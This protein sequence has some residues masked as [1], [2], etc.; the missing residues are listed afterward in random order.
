MRDFYLILNSAIAIALFALGVATLFN[1]RK[2]IVNKLFMAFTASVGVWLVAAC[3]SND[4]RNSATVSLYGNYLVF[5]FSYISSYLLLRFAVLVTAIKRLDKWM[6]ILNVPLI[7]VGI[8]SATPLVVAGVEPQGNVYAINFGPLVW[9]YALLLILQ[10][11]AVIWIFSKGVRISTGRK[12][13]QIKIIWQSLVI[14]IPILMITQ[15]IAPAIT[16][17]FEITD[18][19]ILIMVLPV[20]SLYMSVIRHGLFDIRQAIIRT[21]TY[22]LSLATLSFVYYYLAY[23]GSVVL[24]KGDVVSGVSVSP[25]NVIMALMLAFLF[26]P[27]KRFFDRVTNRIFYK[28]N[29]NTDD[30]FAELNRTLS[31]TTDLRGLLER[32]ASEIADT[33]KAEQAFFFIFTTP[34]GHYITA[35]TD[36]HKLLPKRDA[37]M[38]E[39]KSQGINNAFTSSMFEYDDSVRRMMVSHRI[40]L[41]LPLLQDDAVVGYLCLGEHKTSNY[42]NRDLK[43]LNTISDELVIAIQNA[44]AVQE[45]RELN[46]S[47]QQKIA[48][49]TKELRSSNAVLRRLDEIKDE[50][51]S[52]ASHQLRTPLTSVKGYLSMVLEGDVGKISPSQKKLL[53]QAYMSSENMVHLINDFLNVSRIQSGKFVIDKTEVDLSRLVEEEVNRLRPNAAA[54]GMKLV[55]KKPKKFPVLELDE[56][57]VRQV[58]MNFA[59]NAIY[60]SHENSSI[61][62]NLGVTKDEIVFTV[63]DTGIGVPESEKNKLFS[64]FYRAANARV[65]RPDGTGVGIY[66]AKKV[67]DAH[68]GQIIFESVEGKGSTF[69]FRL[70]LPAK[71]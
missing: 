35:G 52:M 61:S 51:I 14:A 2:P 58:V 29:Y 64:K 36:G 4:T 10:L 46:A 15:F 66:L 59:D 17:S 45:I 56:G 38:F 53:D 37:V 48:N 44:L 54:R 34:D 21:A 1:D 23:L 13:S 20:I 30:F 16:G 55:Y 47:L 33:L 60:Y 9:L 12:R 49:A 24:F 57:K 27:V 8:L 39:Q 19:G 5:F 68:G 65:Q 70:P 11:V 32:T 40:E 71:D 3:V 69:G 62:I 18:A 42:T 26:Q 67:V 41:V 28:D 6:R 50:F 22:L 7:L 25:I 31:T 63:K 43:A